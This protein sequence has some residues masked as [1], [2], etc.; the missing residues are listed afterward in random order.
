MSGKRK[1]HKGR[2]LRTGEGQRKDLTYQYRYTD[3]T[4][5]RHT[6]YAASLDELWK[7]EDQ[8]NASQHVG[9]DYAGGGITVIELL[10]RYLSLKQGVTT[11]RK[12]A[13]TSC[14]AW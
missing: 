1:D 6:V 10:E 14:W 13:I 3:A 8:I 11:T 7:K 9:L 5:K 4:G 2:I 12:L